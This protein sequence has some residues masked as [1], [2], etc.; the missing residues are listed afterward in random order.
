MNRGRWREKVASI[1]RAELG[2]NLSPRGAAFSLAT[3]V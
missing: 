1:V 2:K 3:G